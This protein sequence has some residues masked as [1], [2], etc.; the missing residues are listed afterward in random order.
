[1]RIFQGQD[2]RRFLHSDRGEQETTE[3]D[4]EK[5]LWNAFGSVIGANDVSNEL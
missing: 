2:V 5:E 4:G 3:M 1:M